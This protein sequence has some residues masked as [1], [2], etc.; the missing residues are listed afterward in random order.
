MNIEI[1]TTAL[2]LDIAKADENIDD[3]EI[4]TIQNILINFF[5]ISIEES[6]AII[7]NAKQHLEDSTDRYQFCKKINS[8]F[9]YQQKIQFILSIY[10]I[11]FIDTELHYLEEHLIKQIANLLHVEHHDLIEAKLEIKNLLN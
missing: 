11:A 2:L 8:E 6:L 4:K 10:K 1:S 5:N 3:N 9:S 7:N